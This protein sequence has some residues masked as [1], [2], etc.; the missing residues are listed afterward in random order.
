MGFGFSFLPKEG[1]T[2][3]TNSTAIATASSTSMAIHLYVSATTHTSFVI[4]LESA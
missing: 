3:R 4:K 1:A 2:T